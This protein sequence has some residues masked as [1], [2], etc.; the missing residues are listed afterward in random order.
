MIGVDKF[1]SFLTPCG[2][3]DSI[4]SVSL[5]IIGVIQILGGFLVWI[6]TFRKPI[7]SFILGLMIFFIGWHLIDGT[8]DIGGAVFLGVLSV[9]LMKTPSLLSS[10]SI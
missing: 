2:L 1:Q 6:P 5:K 3:L 9:L 8:Y 10:K 4:P 7:A